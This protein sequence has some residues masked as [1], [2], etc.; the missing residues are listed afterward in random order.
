MHCGT[1]SLIVLQARHSPRKDEAPFVCDESTSELNLSS[2]KKFIGIPR[3]LKLLL[4][5]VW[6]DAKSQM[7]VVLQ[8]PS[9]LV[10]SPRMG[11]L[12]C[13]S[14]H[15]VPPGTGLAS[16][17]VPGQGSF[18]TPASDCSWAGGQPEQTLQ[19]RGCVSKGLCL[20]RGLHAGSASAP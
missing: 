6:V 4:H 14:V 11:Y 18:G 2:E 8:P 10:R 20:Q 5:G 19:G 16:A 1:T 17:G 3:R 12:S 15:C 13:T 9:F 7:F